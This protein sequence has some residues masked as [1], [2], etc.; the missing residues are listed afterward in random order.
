LAREGLP[1]APRRAQTSWRSF[2]RQHAATTLACDFF[3]VETVWMQR[4]YVLF[5]ISPA[6]RR[7][8][9]VACM[10]NPNMAWMTQQARNGLIEFDDRQQRMLLLIHDRDKKFSCAFDAMFRSDGISII[11]TPIQAPNANAYAERW[12]GSVRRECLDRILIFGR[13]Q[14]DTVLRVYAC[15][16]NQLRP[17]RALELRPPT[18]VDGPLPRRSD[19]STV[20][21]VQRHDLLGGRLHKYQAA[22]RPHL[23]TPRAR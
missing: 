23:C 21:S 6:T 8:E 1:P 18:S 16:Y 20:A 9:F 13:R 22:A 2:L 3:T 10:T 15:H 14:L 17:H 5:F 19:P 4:L 11:R 12:V 7:I